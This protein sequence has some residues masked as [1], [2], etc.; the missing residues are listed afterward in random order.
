ML[1]L[2]NIPATLAFLYQ[3]LPAD[4]YSAANITSADIGYPHD[5][6][7][8]IAS[9]VYL[10][11]THSISASQDNKPDGT[12]ALAQ[13]NKLLTGSTPMVSTAAVERCG[14]PC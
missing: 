6:M 11:E 14:P 7:A 2:R 5:A 10:H 1:A 3:V 4:T 13:S 12:G 8:D 9:V